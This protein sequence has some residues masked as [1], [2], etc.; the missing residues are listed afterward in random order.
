MIKSDITYLLHEL[1][2]KSILPKFRT[3]QT[4]Q[5]AAAYSHQHNKIKWEV[6]VWLLPSGEAVF[7]LL[8]EKIGVK[9]VEKIRVMVE[10]QDGT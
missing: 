7:L 5:I 8:V 1:E 6:R 2:T 9:G 10:G 4:S 3:T